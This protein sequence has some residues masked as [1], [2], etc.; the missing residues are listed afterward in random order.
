MKEPTPFDDLV[1]GERTDAHYATHFDEI[2]SAAK[3]L[4]DLDQRVVA[5]VIPRGARVLDVMCGTGRHLVQL[6]RRRVDVVGN[7]YNPHMLE[8]AEEALRSREYTPNLTQFDVVEG[9]TGFADASFDWVICM[10]DSLGAIPGHR[11]RQRA[12]REMARVTRVGGQLLVH[13]H[14]LLAKFKE[15][16]AAWAVPHVLD[17]AKRAKNGT[18]L[19]DVR[20]NAYG[21][22]SARRQP[23]FIHLH[24]PWE[25]AAYLTDADLE[26]TDFYFC[27]Y[28]ARQFFHVSYDTSDERNLYDIGRGFCSSDG[29]IVRARRPGS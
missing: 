20:V 6:A 27:D 7:D 21:A 19:G 3:P 4:F 14:N 10:F 28:G 17:Y 22:G 1:A 24:S 8:V 25:L 23:S 11:N 9:L 26:V 29:V 5:E 2:E 12:V 16:D 15:K 18:E 13:G